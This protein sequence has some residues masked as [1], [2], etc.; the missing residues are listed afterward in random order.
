MPARVAS[1]KKLTQAI[2]RQL[3]YFLEGIGP[4]F[5][6]RRPRSKIRKQ[7]CCNLAQYYMP[8]LRKTVVYSFSTVFFLHLFL[9]LIAHLFDLG[10]CYSDRLIY[11]PDII[12]PSIFSLIASKMCLPAS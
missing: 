9:L 4:C 8:P 3:K 10:P 12:N 2:C 6:V 1:E 7:G 5:F 11:T